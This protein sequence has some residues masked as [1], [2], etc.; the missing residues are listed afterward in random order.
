MAGRPKKKKDEST[1][2]AI[3]EPVSVQVLGADAMTAGDG[4]QLP[5]KYES[6]HAQAGDY[7][8]D[9]LKKADDNAKSLG[10]QSDLVSRWQMIVRFKDI[11]ELVRHNVHQMQIVMQEQYE[12]FLQR[13]GRI[14]KELDELLEAAMSSP[15]GM[16]MMLTQRTKLD[17]EK[18]DMIIGMQNT[19]RT[20]AALSKEYRQCALMRAFFV[21]VSQVSEFST[22][23]KG[24]ITSAIQ[25]PDTLKK[26]A[27]GIEIATQKCFPAGKGGDEDL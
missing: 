26:I 7:M 11:N 24:V 27:S 4:S 3:V 16:D 12:Y 18:N 14:E 10:L 1:E 22:M 17:K 2:V 25:D 23:L 15:E 19:A 13:K 6:A 5:E 9:V 20:I 21:H 8:L